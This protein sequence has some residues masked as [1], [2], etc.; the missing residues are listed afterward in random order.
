MK[1]FKNILFVTV[2]TLLIMFVILESFFRIVIPAS[3]HP[4][5]FFDESSKMLLFSDAPK[6]GMFTIG[7]F[8][9][10]RAR[11][12]INNMRW[13]YPD[14]YVE[15]HGKKLIA[16]IGDSYVEGLQV[17][18]DKNFSYLLK[19]KLG[20]E[21]EVYAFGK[22]GGPLSHYLHI[23]RYAEQFDPQILVFNIVH[24]DFDESVFE[25][26]PDKTSF[27]Q[28][29]INNDEITETVPRPVLSTRQYSTWKNLL[30]R[31]ALVRYLFYNLQLSQFRTALN[32]RSEQNYEGNVSLNSMERE[33]EL[34]RK[35]TDHII[36]TIAE[37]NPGKRVIFVIDAPRQAIY[38]D[39]LKKSEIIK[40]NR[41]LE[42]ICE[43]YKVEFI[44]LTPLMEVDYG[45]HKRKFNSD[46]D[47]HWDEY[48][49]EFVAGVLCDY[50]TGQ[51]S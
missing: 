6:T 4:G 18:V 29:A 5:N 31:S 34:S 14:D 50:L 16:V 2:P 22:S 38:S 23:S 51:D 20:D 35:A 1:T 15:V 30:Y 10:I 24:N 37:E 19:K 46:L 33:A 47:G 42:E 27:M 9:E 36:K 28:L 45:K 49:H 41:M 12:R 8:A 26:H 3:L 40:L 17:D 32:A 48:G 25:L 39:T 44:D 7:K 43:K 21:Y 11:W 13:N